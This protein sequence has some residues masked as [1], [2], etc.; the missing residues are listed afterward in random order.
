MSEPLK[1]I[2]S[3]EFL[4]DF[5]D[6]VHKV[7]TEFNSELFTACVL[8]PPWAEL[9]LKARIH[10]IAEKLGEYLPKDFEDALQILFLINED[11][12]GFPYLFFPDFVATYGQNKKHFELS[13][14]ALERFTEQSSSEFAIRPFLLNDPERVMVYMFKWSLHKNEHIRR[15]S[16]EGCRP[17]LPWGTS[18]PMFK[19]NPSPILKILE[20]LM[21]DTS[22]YV[23]KSVAN[24]LND[25]SK[26][27]PKVVIELVKKWI[28]YSSETDWILRKGCRT[29]VR[30]AN[31]IALDLFG[32]TDFS[33]E[34][35]L[36]KNVIFNV[37]P[38]ELKIG[39]SC[40]LNYSIDIV[41]NTPSHIR[42]EYGI[43]FIKSNSRLSRKLFFLSDKTMSGGEHLSGRRTH[44]FADL[45][46][47]K[48]YPG[49]HK[50]T[51]L[52]NGIEIAHSTLN[53]IESK[54]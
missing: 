49:I 18:L 4:K 46:T 9:E 12:V 50:I 48:H 13:M 39:D 36:F 42:L 5:G 22:L 54:K 33:D 24:N 38:K 23:R 17:R 27:N 26:D 47:R 51:L 29:L 20:N 8:S 7:Y 15:F 31:P 10:K 44:N 40:E 21:A 11:C 1:N 37:T 43:D 53:I 30:N 2:Y 34:N 32:Y 19:N 3:S 16:S 25:I 52:V 41:R 45:T 35:P 14:N 6:K 28:G